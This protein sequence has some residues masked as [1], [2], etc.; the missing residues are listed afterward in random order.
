MAT[1]KNKSPSTIMIDPATQYP[2]DTTKQDAKNMAE[3]MDENYEG[4]AKAYKN[5]RQSRDPDLPENLL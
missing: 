2:R 4:M 1:P 5:Y 3:G